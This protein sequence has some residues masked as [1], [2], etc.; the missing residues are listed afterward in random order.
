M[1]DTHNE[2]APRAPRLFIASCVVLL[3]AVVVLMS[4]SR[5]H[6][7]A[8]FAAVMAVLAAGLGAGLTTLPVIL[9]KGSAAGGVACGI[10]GPANTTQNVTI[11]QR[12][13]RLGLN[14]VGPP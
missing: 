3:L 7:V 6:K 9:R 1:S 12:R 2:W 13:W 14:D 11:A 10:G 5:G 4:Q 8:F